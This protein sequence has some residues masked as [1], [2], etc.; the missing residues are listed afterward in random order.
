MATHTFP[1]G[2]TKDFP[3]GGQMAFIDGK[4]FGGCANCCAEKPSEMLNKAAKGRKLISYEL[5]CAD[6]ASPFHI[7]SAEGQYAPDKYKAKT[8]IK[9]NTAN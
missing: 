9:T 3:I 8:P 5:E 6:C 1:D 7:V 4:V 2:R